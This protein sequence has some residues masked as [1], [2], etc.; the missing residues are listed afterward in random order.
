MRKGKK[1]QALL[2]LYHVSP[3]QLLRQ[4]PRWH[5]QWRGMMEVLDE[6]EWW[7]KSR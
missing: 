1:N 5:K 7:G 2:N 3:A 6:N 4:S